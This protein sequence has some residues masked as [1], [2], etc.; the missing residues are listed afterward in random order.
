MKVDYRRRK[1]KYINTKNREFENYNKRT[2]KELKC[3]N[4]KLHRKQFTQTSHK[5]IHTN[6]PQKC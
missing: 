6:T 2:I 5:A 3:N 4:H 1:T